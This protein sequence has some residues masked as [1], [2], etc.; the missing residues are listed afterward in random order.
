MELVVLRVAGGWSI[1]TEGRRR[2]RYE[3]EVDAVEAAL[4]MA[5]ELRR[6]HAKV[7]VILQDRFGELRPVED[8]AGRA[9]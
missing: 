6:T 4:R 3:F 1:V 5:A 8:I 7:S 2:G 9:A